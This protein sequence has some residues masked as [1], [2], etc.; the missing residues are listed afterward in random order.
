MLLLDA[1][2]QNKRRAFQVL[3]ARL[4]DRKLTK[5][6]ADRRAV[7]QNLVRTADRSEKVRTYNYPQVLTPLFSAPLSFPTNLP[8]G[9]RY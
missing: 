5:E 2:I 6:M 3:R 4:M 8:P 9:P 7:R 1:G